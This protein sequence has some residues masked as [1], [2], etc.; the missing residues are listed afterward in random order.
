MQTYPPPIVIMD[1]SAAINNSEPC[2]KPLSPSMPTHG[3][4]ARS[5]YNENKNV[6]PVPKYACRWPL[7]S[8][9]LRSNQRVEQYAPNT[10]RIQGMK[11]NTKLTNCFAEKPNVSNINLPH[12]CMFWSL[13]VLVRVV[14]RVR[15]MLSMNSHALP[16]YTKVLVCTSLSVPVAMTIT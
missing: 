16:L 5:G 14:Q 10:C 12:Y 15:R 13:K 2:P 1:A 6:S 4:L 3:Y 11:K 7:S 8:F 9:R